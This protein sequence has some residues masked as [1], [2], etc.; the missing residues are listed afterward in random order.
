MATELDNTNTS[1]VSII[2]SLPLPS[3]LDHGILPSL[4]APFEVDSAILNPLPPPLP[5]DT[6][7]LQYGS[8]SP[9]EPQLEHPDSNEDGVLPQFDEVNDQYDFLRRTLS[10]SQRRYSARY[11]RPRPKPQKEKEEQSSLDMPGQRREMSPYRVDQPT[12]KN[13]H[14]LNIKHHTVRGMHAHGDYQQQKR[15]HRRSTDRR[16]SPAT[17]RRSMLNNQ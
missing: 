14:P 11:K 9:S 12:N 4:S 6:H 3:T 10:H 2:D 8:S 16:S 13:S 7:S 1:D 5:I 17:V 15:V